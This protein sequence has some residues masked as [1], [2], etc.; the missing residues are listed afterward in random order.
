MLEH[1]QDSELGDVDFNEE[2]IVPFKEKYNQ[3]ANAINVNMSDEEVNRVF[4]EAYYTLINTKFIVE[5]LRRDYLERKWVKE[6]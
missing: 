4:D 3:Y 6:K 1:W 5:A 2:V